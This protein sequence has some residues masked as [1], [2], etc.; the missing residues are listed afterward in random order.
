MW[1]KL[2]QKVQ[3]K[4][5]LKRW[6]RH[7]GRSQEFGLPGA[8]AI[9]VI[10]AVRL[11]GTFQVVE[12]FMFDRFMRYR[13][14][15]QIDTRIT[16]VGIT[17]RDIPKAGFPITDAE[18]AKLINRINSF[19]PKAIGLDIF[20][21]LPVASGRQELAKLFRQTK[22]LVVIEKSV[23]PDEH[24]TFINPPPE[25]PPEQVGFADVLLDADG[26]IRRS[27]L[28]GVGRL[29]F[30]AKLSTLY[31]EKQ[32]W[33][34]E[35]GINDPAAFRFRSVKDS[36]EL[37]RFQANDG[38]YIRGDSFGNQILLNWRNSDR[39]PIISLYDRSFNR[40][41][42]YKS[43]YDPN[44][45][46]NLI[47]DR[48]V[49]VGYIAPFSAKDTISVPAVSDQLIYG[50]EFHAYSI[51]QILSNVLD[52]RTGINSLPDALEYL[53]IAIAGIFGIWIS[54][55]QTSASRVLLL[56]ITACFFIIVIC[57]LGMLISWWLPVVPTVLACAIAGM[58]TR[59]VDD[60]RSLI[61]KTQELSAQRQQTLDEAFNALHNGPLHSLAELIGKARENELE[62]ALLSHKLENLD[63]ELRQV[64]ETLR[65]DSMQQEILSPLHELVA[66]V[67]HKALQRDFIGYKQLKFTIPDIHPVDDSALSTQ[68][69]R[70][71][72]SFL[73]EAL[74]NVGK[75]AIGSTKLRVVC[76]QENQMGYLQVIDNGVGIE[77][78]LTTKPRGGT[79]HALQLAKQMGGNFRREPNPPKGTIC[80]ISWSI[81]GR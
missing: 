27:L 3:L 7:L 17:E 73:D 57:Y 31:L 46:P 33:N 35:N 34:L 6:Q 23:L 69:K 41:P 77:A 15:E 16:I 65:P 71:L 74:C 50:V 20:R 40:S 12:W 25:L 28:A 10:L 70:E 51:S 64:Y 63:R 54:T 61:A 18:L 52:G 24:N 79:S 5:S 11:S 62:S 66:E 13:L 59:Y 48:I 81:F 32:G 58:V 8:I 43:I 67:M 55:S 78:G 44:F 39:F 36:I 37:K 2:A 4:A 22:N 80:E 75:H 19:Q 21:D 56:L 68:Q 29:S 9:A 72:C 47:R 45:D 30:A 49:L 1:A 42:Q 14:L 53:T 60:L 26:N 76:K 38:G